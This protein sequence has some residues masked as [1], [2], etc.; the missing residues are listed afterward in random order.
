MHLARFI[1]FYA[2]LLS[3]LIHFAIYGLPYI[4][5]LLEEEKEVVKVPVNVRIVDRSVPV[6]VGDLE[7]SF[8]PE[9]KKEEPAKI[10]VPKKAVLPVDKSS[11]GKKKEK[12]PTPSQDTARTLPGQKEIIGKSDKAFGSP[13]GVLDGV[14]A[15]QGEKD[16]SADAELIAGSVEIPEYTEG[17]L[18]AGFEGLVIVEVFVDVNGRVTEAEIEKKIGYGMDKRLIDSAKAA[19]FIPRKNSKGQPL[20]SWTRIPFRLV[21]P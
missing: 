13:D 5:S 3:L 16:L 4:Y 6:R 15:I 11:K 10:P 8:I 12:E 19:R 21:I 18:D 2:L 9:E 7:G 14:V 17:A 1:I 20:A